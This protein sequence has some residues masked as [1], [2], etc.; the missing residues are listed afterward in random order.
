MRTIEQALANAARIKDELPRMIQPSASDYDMVLLAARVKEC[1]KVMQHY[2]METEHSCMCQFVNDTDTLASEC[3]YHEQ[4]RL[5]AEQAEARLAELER[6]YIE[7]RSAIE[8]GTPLYDTLAR[9]AEA[10]A[11]LREAQNYAIDSSGGS[12]PYAKAAEGCW[13]RIDAFL[14]RENEHV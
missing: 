3:H 4:V 5:R 7:F 9:L 14:A 8:R 12:T 2:G 11:L 13:Q 6:E 1:E 10:E